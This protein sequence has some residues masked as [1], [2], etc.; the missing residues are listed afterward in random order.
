[1]ECKN[2]L[3]QL[4]LSIADFAETNKR[5]PARVSEG[6]VGGWTIEILP[7]IDQ[8]NLMDRVT[9]G[10]PVRSAPDFLLKQPR[11]FRCPVRA[12]IDGPVA[13]QMDLSG[14]VLAPLDRR[15]S[16]SVLDSPLGVKFPW[17]SGGEMK[18]D[19]VIRQAG[20]HDGGFFSA[21]GFQNGVNF[22]KSV[23]DAP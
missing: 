19:D 22:V 12:T 16:Y 4:N 18:F 2:N 8:K 13:G 11:V 17:A 10:I 15:D 7:F 5:L 21:S 9:P 23:K 6:L 20:P 14:Y 3:H 1:M